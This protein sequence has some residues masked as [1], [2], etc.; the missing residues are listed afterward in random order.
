VLDV[1][2][3]TDSVGFATM[4]FFHG[5]GLSGGE[6]Y[7]PDEWKDKGIAVVTANY[8]L[9]PRVWLKELQGFNHGNMVAPASLLA[10][11]F[12]RGRYP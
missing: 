1:Y 12:L 4:I 5:G 6:K 7:I 3:P 2:Y 11:D 9:H 8:R 10:L